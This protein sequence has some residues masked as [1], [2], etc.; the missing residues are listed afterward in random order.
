M[1]PSTF[2][3][4]FNY[5]FDRSYFRSKI[6]EDKFVRDLRAELHEVNLSLSL[7]FVSH[8]VDA[9]ENRATETIFTTV[10]EALFYSDELR[11]CAGIF[12]QSMGARNLVGIGL[13]YRP[14]RQHSLAGIDSWAP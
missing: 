14:A 6:I 10:L 9:I 8:G 7:I 2:I 3:C 13:S 4:P 1:E 5:R 11:S 12:E